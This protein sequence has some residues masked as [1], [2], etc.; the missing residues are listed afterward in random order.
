MSVPQNG[1]ESQSLAV[2]HFWWEII[3]K[4]KQYFKGILLCFS[5]LLVK[6]QL[7]VVM[8]RNNNTHMLTGR[9]CLQMTVVHV[10]LPSIFD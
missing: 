6:L 1:Q 5:D 8:K 2:F 3:L 9:V 4:P 10:F 7:V